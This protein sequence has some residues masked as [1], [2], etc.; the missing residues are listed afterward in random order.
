MPL[1]IGL[2]LFDGGPTLPIPVD[3]LIKFFSAWG[4]LERDVALTLNGLLFMLLPCPTHVYWRRQLRHLYSID[5]TLIGD[6]GATMCCFPCA[7]CQESREVK[8]RGG[9]Y[10]G[11]PEVLEMRSR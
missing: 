5:G 8:R 7:V 2:E 9:N 4:C 6:C 1:R 10:L 11:L 3:L